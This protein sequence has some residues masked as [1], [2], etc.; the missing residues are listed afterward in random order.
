MDEAWRQCR[1]AA[2]KAGGE[3]W[4]AWIDAHPGG[5]PTLAEIGASVMRKREAMD[6]RRAA[7]KARKAAAKPPRP[8]GG[9]AGGRRGRGGGGSQSGS[10][11]PAAASESH[12][13]LSDPSALPSP[14][15]ADASQ[16][17]PFLPPAK[18]PPPSGPDNPILATGL[19]YVP[20]SK[21][22][23]PLK[24]KRM[25][26]ACDKHA[27]SNASSNQQAM[28]V[29]CPLQPQPQLPP[30]P[31]RSG[32]GGGEGFGNGSPGTSLGTDPLGV[33]SWPTELGA[34]MEL[35]EFILTAASVQERSDLE[36]LFRED[37]A[38][39]L[40][41]TAWTYRVKETGPD[42]RERPAAVRDV[43][44][45]PWP[46]QVSSI[47]RIA[48]CVRDGRDVVIRKSRDMGASWLVVGLAAWGWLFHGWQSLLVSRVE[49][50]VDRTGDPDSL[51]WKV[52]YILASQPSWLLPCPVDQMRKGG[53]FR[54]HMVLRHPTS[55]ATIAG[56]AS[57]A[58]IGRGGRRTFVLFDEF[59]ALEDDEAAWRSASDTTSCRIALSTPIGYG[60][61]Y[62]KLVQE[63]RG[64]GNP[65]LVEMLYWHHPEKAKGAETK[66]DFDG[67]VTGVTGGTYVWTPW[68]GDQL[69]K[70]DKVDLAQNVFAEAMGAGA[71]FFPSVAV[72][73][74]RREFGREPRRANWVSGRW[75]DSPTGRW[76]LWG[77]PEVSSYSVGID[78]AYGTGNHASAVAVLDASTRRMVAMMVDANIT[79]AD[80]AAEVA[81][82]CRGCFREAVVAWEVNGP[83]QSLQRDFEAQRFHRVWKPRREGKSTHGIVD[84]IG[85]VSSEQSKRLLLGNLSRAVQQGEVVVPCTGTLDEMLAYVLDGNGRV[86][87][88]RLRDESTGARENHGDRVIALALAWLAADDAPVP[89]Q[90]DEVYADG[91]A[92]DLLKH[93]E[94]FR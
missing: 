5:V 58:H 72:T 33:P 41:L 25:L 26:G 57:G 77:D 38:A 86:I 30:L 70:R 9:V 47:R 22:D 71:A 53:S 92:G 56:Q 78:P 91:S 45:V 37:P 79:P 68:L 94:V 42:G 18:R 2:L 63:A 84:R 15:D 14:S 49:D 31:P 23:K 46:V 24:K 65:E 8:G 11:G 83:G 54:Q 66:V 55:G 12:S 59:A 48:A 67:T 4:R 29:E 36:A 61:R 32:G 27:S 35:R 62:D 13:A 89:G 39:W 80:L 34:L 28:L 81:D 76:R 3:T 20:K 40:A 93:W 17:R 82:V 60:T 85:W 16:A 64:T 7:H 44:F 21:S 43:P 90:E 50:N 87:P 73:A 6:A 52:D 51:F 88:G 19:K 69:R 1:A 74:H 10:P 75:V